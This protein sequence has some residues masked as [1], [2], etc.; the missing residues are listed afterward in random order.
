MPRSLLP[1][2]GVIIPP[3]IAYD[4]TMSPAARD[5]YMQLRGLA[6]GKLE[7]PKMSLEEL[8]MITGKSRSTIYGHLAYLRDR[9]VLRYV[10]ADDKTLVVSFIDEPVQS[11][12][13]ESLL[14]SSSSLDINSSISEEKKEKLVPVQK[15][16]QHTTIGKKP[17]KADPR[18][19][20]P[21][22]QCVKSVTSRYPPKELYD[23]IIRVLGEKPDAGLLAALRKEWVKRG[24]NPNGWGWLL[25]WYNL[26][27]V[28]GRNEKVITK[29]SDYS[30]Y[31]NGHGD[32]Y[33][34][35]E[36]AALQERILA[37]EAEFAKRKAEKDAYNREKYPELYTDSGRL[38]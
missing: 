18:T 17:S 11:K 26:R 22:I 19:F 16:G 14:N 15:T 24:Y 9:G 3:N 37:Q 32:D 25:D 36:A 8:S 27:R 20:T 23:D 29:Q 34:P 7:T 2:K 13:L 12:N 5:T 1:P 10:N 4:T 30:G 31:D 21:A 35:A 33:D 6:W 28:P 38:R